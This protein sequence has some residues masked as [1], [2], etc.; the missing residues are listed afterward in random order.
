MYLGG[1]FLL[2]LK[3][4]ISELTF[5]RHIYCKADSRLFWTPIFSTIPFIE[6]GVKIIVF[7]LFLSK[8]IVNAENG[9]IFV[10]YF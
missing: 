3:S 7:E 4:L 8:S 6:I 5:L 2:V 10:P 9:G 1:N